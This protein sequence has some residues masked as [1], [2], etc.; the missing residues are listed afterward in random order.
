MGKHW[1]MEN[2]ALLLLVIMAPSSLVAARTT[3]AKQDW[4]PKI[5]RKYLVGVR[6]PIVVYQ[7][8]ASL[9]SK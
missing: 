7:T 8:H 6:N 1:I 4:S 9:D 2:S 3:D 5:F